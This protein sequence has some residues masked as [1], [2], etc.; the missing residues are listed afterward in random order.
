MTKSGDKRTEHPGSERARDEQRSEHGPQY[1]GGAWRDADRHDD[2]ERSKV[3]A[4]EEDAGEEDAGEEATGEEATGEE[5]AG[6]EAT[7]EIES[8]GQRAGMR[9]GEAPR[10]PKAE[11]P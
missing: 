8:G 7:G 5:D 9:R 2:G 10:R 1:E 6:E 11:E 4:D 3:A